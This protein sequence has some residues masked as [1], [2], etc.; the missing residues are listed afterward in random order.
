MSNW[1]RHTVESNALRINYYRTGGDKPPVILSHGA[2]DD[3]LCWTRVVKALE[4]DYDVVMVDA[5][6][7]GLSESGHGDYS[8]E[9]LAKDLVG[10]IQAFRMDRPIIGGH[11]M[12]AN[13]S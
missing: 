13:T 12:G 6:G 8:S 2:F 5:R 3:G 1:P 9:A 7:H 11:S 10:V 4:A